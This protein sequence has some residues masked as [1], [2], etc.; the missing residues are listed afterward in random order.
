MKDQNVTVSFATGKVFAPVTK[1]PATVS[2][3][4]GKNF[5]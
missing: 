2:F 5:K 1:A 3:A 4:T